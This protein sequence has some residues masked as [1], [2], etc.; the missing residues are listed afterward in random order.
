M[1]N[2]RIIA[3]TCLLAATLALAGGVAE[4]AAQMPTGTSARRWDPRGLQATRAELE[5]MLEQLEETARSSAYSSTLRDHARAEAEIIRNRLEEGDIRVGDRI[6]LRVEREQF[7]DDL[8][9]V[10]GRKV[11]LPQIGEIP[12]D[13]VLRSELQEHMREHIGRYIRDPVV[14][15]RSL[16]RVQVR[17]AV[18]NPGYFMAP[19]DLLLEDAIMLAGGPAGNARTDRLRIERGRNPIW[20][21]ERLQAAMLEGRT[22]D[23]LSIRAGDDIVVPADRSRFAPLRNV[24][25]VVSSLASI[26]LLANRLGAF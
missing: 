3:R 5:E 18:R 14:H 13:G 1:R 4:A 24:M 10:A 22:L 9:V 26:A 21:G 20:Q 11:I 2:Y 15:A 7:P 16:I 12:L 23:Q 17:G 8:M 19:S 6:M 25:V